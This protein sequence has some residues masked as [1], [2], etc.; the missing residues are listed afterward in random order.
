[1]QSPASKKVQLDNIQN[2]QLSTGVKYDEN[3]QMVKIVIISI[4]AIALA[5]FAMRFLPK[6]RFFIQRLLQNPFV[7][8]I[9]FR[10]LWR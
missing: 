10:G 1:V 2:G 9:L 3:I 7:R 4:F 5:I 6:L 8:A